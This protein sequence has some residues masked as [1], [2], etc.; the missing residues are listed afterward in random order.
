VARRRVATHET[1]TVGRHELRLLRRDRR[2]LGIAD[3]RAG[4]EGGLLATPRRLDRVFH[5]QRPRMVQ[6]Q[7]GAVA[8]QQRGVGQPG[9]IVRGGEAGDG[10]RRLDGLAQGLRREIGGA[11]VALALAAIDGDADALVAVELDGLDFIAAHADRLPE[12]FGDIDFA[13]GRPLVAGMFQDIL[14]ELLQR[15]ERVGKAGGFGHESDV[16]AGKPLS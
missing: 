16:R 13:G 6:I 15:R 14:G 12:A 7:I 1:E 2:A 10:E 11:G 5:G 8:G 9:A 4:G 3:Q